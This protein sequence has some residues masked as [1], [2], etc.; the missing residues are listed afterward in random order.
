MVNINST[1]MCVAFDCFAHIP[2]TQN[3]TLTCLNLFK[4]IVIEKYQD[5]DIA[6]RAI[7]HS[8]L[9]SCKNERNNEIERKYQE[10]GL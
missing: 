3:P 9:C 6:L 7:Q 4:E 2:I 8:K 1:R 10:T 5:N